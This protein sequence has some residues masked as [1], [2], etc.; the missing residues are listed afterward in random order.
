MRPNEL[1]ILVARVGEPR[2]NFW[3]QP[4]AADCAKTRAAEPAGWVSDS[5]LFPV[6]FC[7]GKT[8]GFGTRI[9][10]E[11]WVA[12]FGGSVGDFGLVEMR[13]AAVRW[14]YGKGFGAIRNSAIRRPILP[15]G[16]RV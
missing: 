2:Q 16:K 8:R 10:R 13:S 7:G 5:A 14:S 3:E 9:L 11:D 1:R 4:P 12:D 15:G 6:A